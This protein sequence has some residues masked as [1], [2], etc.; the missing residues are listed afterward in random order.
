MIQRMIIATFVFGAFTTA[1]S[2][3]TPDW[4]Q[5][6]RIDVDLSNYAFAP[7]EIHLQHGMPYDL[8]LSNSSAKSHDFSAP[9]FFASSTIKPD[10]QSLAPKG[11]VE[12]ETQQAV[13][14]HVIPNQA[15]SYELRCTHFMH[16]MLGMSGRIIVD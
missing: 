6:K 10:D 5:A 13:D 1:A 4:S 3:Q 14:V 9:A 16:T 7:K 12:L 2:A 15:G 11:E 8:H